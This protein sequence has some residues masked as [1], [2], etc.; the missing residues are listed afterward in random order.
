MTYW[1][2]RL[3]YCRA[4]HSVEQFCRICTRAFVHLCCGGLEPWGTTGVLYR[5]GTTHPTSWSSLWNATPSQCCTPRTVLQSFLQWALCP[6]VH[7]RPRDPLSAY[8]SPWSPCPHCSPLPPNR[9]SDAMPW[10]RAGIWVASGC[11]ARE[12]HCCHLLLTAV[13]FPFPRIGSQTT[14]RRR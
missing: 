4:F 10:G 1:S 8:L 14:R 9:H 12:S 7:W 6:G 5:K 11:L 3:C 2:D 13:F